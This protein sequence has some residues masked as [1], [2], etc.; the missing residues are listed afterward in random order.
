MAASTNV[1]NAFQQGVIHAMLVNAQSVTLHVLSI[2]GLSH[3][4]AEFR[5]HG[6]EICCAV[7]N[8]TQL[9]AD[10]LRKVLT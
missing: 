6:G 8:S 3:P 1:I 2:V 9:V 7:I 4:P 5:Q 10:K